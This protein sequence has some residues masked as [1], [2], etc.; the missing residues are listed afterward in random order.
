MPPP[1]VFDTPEFTTSDAPPLVDSYDM[2]PP[3]D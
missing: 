2:R 3:Q 1:M